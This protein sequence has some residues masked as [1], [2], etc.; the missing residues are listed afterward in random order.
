MLSWS[1]LVIASLGLWQVVAP[2]ALGYGGAAAANDRVWGALALAAGI[3]GTLTSARALR[4][5]ELLLGSWIVVAA[6]LLPYPLGARFGAAAV[7]LAVAI[8]ATA[9]NGQER[10]AGHPLRALAGRRPVG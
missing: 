4:A 9:A 5:A 7:G 3:A 6:L 10:R 2:A 8:C 1:R